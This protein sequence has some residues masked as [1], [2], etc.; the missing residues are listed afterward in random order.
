MNRFID[1]NAETC[2]KKVF[3]KLCCKKCGPG[4]L[5]AH[6]VATMGYKHI[7]AIMTLE[8]IAV[9]H[10]TVACYSFGCRTDVNFRCVS[11]RTPLKS[12]CTPRTSSQSCSRDS[13]SFGSFPGVKED[14]E[15]WNWPLDLHLVPTWRMGGAIRLLP[16]TPSWPRTNLFTRTWAPYNRLSPE[17]HSFLIPTPDGGEL[18]ASRF[19]CIT[20]LTEPLIS[21]GKEAGWSSGSVRT[22]WLR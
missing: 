5:L 20:P 22:R 14:T 1:T 12:S 13:P 10:I 16:Y 7:I 17:F 21:V 6:A 3:L 9:F 8:T 18:L 4:P 15:A 19:C 11:W 2:G